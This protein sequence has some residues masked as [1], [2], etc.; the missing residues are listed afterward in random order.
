M[1]RGRDTEILKIQAYTDY[2]NSRFNNRTAFISSFIIAYYI[3]LFGLNVQKV[4]SIEQYYVFL[5]VPLPVFIYWSYSAYRDHARKMERIDELIKKLNNLESVPSVK[6]MITGKAW[7]KREKKSL[8]FRDFF[9]FFLKFLYC[10]FLFFWIVNCL[11]VSFYLS[12]L[13]IE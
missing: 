9:G 1:E 12:S 3:S 11:C 8:V 2:C 5:F 10:F 13:L 4:I 7:E 6:D